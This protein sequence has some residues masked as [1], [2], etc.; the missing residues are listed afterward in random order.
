VDQNGMHR[1]DF[2]RMTAAMAG[3]C[4]F[5]GLA[6]GKVFAAPSPALTLGT[7][8]GVWE[9]AFKERVL[10]AF[11]AERQAQVVLDISSS[12]ER[13]A[14]VQAQRDR[15]RLDA[16]M[17]TPEAMVMAIDSGLLEPL[18][19]SSVPNIADVNPR[20]RDIFLKD[21]Q[22]YAC[23]VSWSA[24][25]ILWRKDLVPFEIKTWKDLWRPELKGRIALQNM[26]T[27]G[28][29]DFIIAA[30]IVHGGSQYNVEP[31]WQA[32]RK[33]R[34][35]IKSFF[36]LSS[37]VLN[38]LASGEIWATVT[39]AGQGLPYRDRG[40]EITIPEEGTSYS[41]QAMGIAVNA[42]NNRLAH[43]FMDLSLRPDIQK[44]WAEVTTVAPTNGRTV[45]D[46]ALQ[47]RLVETPDV[48]GRLWD[49]DFYNMARHMEEWSE[50]WQRELV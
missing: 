20:F 21:G 28:A 10:P 23:G 29:A 4:A 27:L 7:W 13:L 32:L 17:L 9:K 37:A 47:S 5:G 2:L 46:S 43:E 31:G 49:T 16:I 18:D 36:T 12:Q 26:P 3:A 39:I 14:K 44:G 45:L 42:P 15:Q 22:L 19:L 48:L 8:G 6:R 41:V 34:P 38:Q 33:L 25:G 40:V 30:A 1:R 24:S 35:N 50:R 11:V